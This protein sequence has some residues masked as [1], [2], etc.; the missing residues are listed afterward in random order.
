[1]S[2]GA[3]RPA[4]ELVGVFGT[5]VLLHQRENDRVKLVFSKRFVCRRIAPELVRFVWLF[6]LHLH[7]YVRG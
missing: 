3:D 6:F 1:V 5:A 4:I 7:L 2:V